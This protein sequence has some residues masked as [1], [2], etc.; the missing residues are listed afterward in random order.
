MLIR[1]HCIDAS[2][3]LFY[4]GQAGG[5]FKNQVIGGDSIYTTTKFATMGDMGSK[6]PATPAANRTKWVA[7][8]YV[9]VGWGP[10]YN[11]GGG[12]QYR[13]CSAG[14]ELTE[15]CFQRHVLPFAG[16]TSTLRWKNGQTLEIAVRARRRAPRPEGP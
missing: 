11:H 10:L 8:T 1:A 2:A 7:G 13:L 4:A 15:E 3:A 5:K 16:G 6:L 14:E 9:E 12:Y